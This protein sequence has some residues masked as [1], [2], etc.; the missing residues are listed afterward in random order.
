MFRTDHDRVV[1]CGVINLQ[2][3]SKFLCSYSM[4]KLY[5]QSSWTEAA[6]FP[7]EGW[8]G[9]GDVTCWALWQKNHILRILVISI[10]IT[11]MI[12]ANSLLSIV[13]YLNPIMVSAQTK[14][15][16]EEKEIQMPLY[17]NKCRTSWRQSFEHNINN[18]LCYFLAKFVYFPTKKMFLLQGHM[19]I[20]GYFQRTFCSWAVE[21]KY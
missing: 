19:E 3:S 20:I 11:R 10:A 9:R 17:L 1:L 6:V 4:L 13:T 8:R 16:G 12:T 14:K 5:V 18:P 2:V 15:T 7:E 21:K